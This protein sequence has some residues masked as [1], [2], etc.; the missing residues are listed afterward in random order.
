V[1]ADC[2][3]F[4]CEIPY[5]GEHSNGAIRE[6]IFRDKI[7]VIKAYAKDHPAGK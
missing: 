1:N 2:T 6:K 4:V 7:A 3:E 5:G